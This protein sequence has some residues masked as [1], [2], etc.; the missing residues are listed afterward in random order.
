MRAS[1]LKQA[2]NYNFLNNLTIKYCDK[3]EEL[4]TISVKNLNAQKPKRRSHLQ[5][6]SDHE[7]TRFRPSLNVN[8]NSKV[9]MKEIDLLTRPNIMVREHRFLTPILELTF[10]G[11]VQVEQKKHFRSLGTQ[12]GPRVTRIQ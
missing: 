5:F 10:M 8:Y 4:G 3:I 6:K 9:I 2:F 1:R 7:R 11:T 12:D